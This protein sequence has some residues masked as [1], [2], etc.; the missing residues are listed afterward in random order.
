MSAELAQNLTGLMGVMVPIVAIVLGIGVAFW[1]IYWDHQKKRLQ[2]QERQ[3]MI[4]K[5]MTP[6]PMLPDEKRRHTPE[7]CLRRGT[8]LLFLGI[9]F[10]IG[11]AVLANFTNDEEFVGIVGVTGAIVGSLGL[12]NLAYY[13]IATRRKREEPV[14]TL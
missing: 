10:A 11:T 13:F 12:G 1:S 6:P 8:I 4:E 7:D 5:G 14:A 3:L 2:Y 9:G